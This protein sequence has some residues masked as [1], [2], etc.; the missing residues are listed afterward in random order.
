[1]S[2]KEVLA[3]QGVV[4]RFGDRVAVDNVSFTVQEGEV[5][6]LLG[7][8][9]AGKTTLMS[10]IAGII[11][12]TSGEVKVFGSS[13][14]NPDTRRLIGFCPQEPVVYENMSGYENM[15]FYAGL[16]G[17]KGSEA[18]RRVS[19][20][21]EFVGLTEYA[22]RP[23][24]E[25]SGGM[26]KRL[27]LAVAL[28]GDPKL[29]LL[30]EPTTGMDPNIRREVWDAIKRLKE[31]GRTVILATHYMEEADALSDRVAIMDRGRVIVEGRPDELKKIYGPKA[32]VALELA[33]VKSELLERLKGYAVEGK[34]VVEGCT[35]RIHVEDPDRAAPELVYEA[36]KSSCTLISLRISTPTLEDVFLRLTGRRLVEEQEG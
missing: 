24:K 15:M 11:K 35:V 13:P 12:P 7:P 32:V 16:H 33:Q 31:E 22:K 5:Y 9:G 27:N 28:V 6:G 14:L 18:K 17:L 36:V 25:Y 23:V 29:I 21:L 2:F 20:L 34:I 30:D 10:I 1:M 26:K 19:E 3:L 8:N 4:K